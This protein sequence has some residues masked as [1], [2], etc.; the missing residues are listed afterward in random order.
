MEN[1]RS[2]IVKWHGPTRKE[3][4]ESTSS[5]GKDG[6]DLVRATQKES[7]KPKT[8]HAHAVVHGTGKGA[9]RRDGA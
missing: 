5:F 4:L 3:R 8:N 6:A 7:S 2:Q 9:G 1:S